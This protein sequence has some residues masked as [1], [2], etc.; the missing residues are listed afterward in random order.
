M[1]SGSAQARP[2]V[3][4]LAK[5]FGFDLECAIRAIEQA[6]SI[7]LGNVPLAQR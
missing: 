5:G 6:K 2:S 1:K 3:E 4:F 7:I